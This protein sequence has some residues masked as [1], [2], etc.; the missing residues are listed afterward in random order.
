[1]TISGYTET[2]RLRKVSFNSRGWHTDLWYN[3]DIIDGALAALTEGTSIPFAVA[4]GTGDAI[5]LDFTPNITYTTS[6]QVQFVAS[7][8]NTGAVT[9]NCDGLGAKALKKADG[10]AY[11]AGD[12]SDGMY[13][14]AVYDSTNDYFTTIYPTLSGL[15]GLI[16]V[17]SGSGVS[18]AAGADDLV[19]DSSGSTP[20]MSILGPNGHTAWM[21]FGR[22]ADVDAGGIGYDHSAN[23]L[24]FR[25]NGNTR[26]RVTDD[27]FVKDYSPIVAAKKAY[28]ASAFPASG[29]VITS[30]AVLNADVETHFNK[31][32]GVFTCPEDDVY[33]V[34]VIFN[35]TGSAGVSHIFAIYKNGVASAYFGTHTVGVS[36]GTTITIPPLFDMVDCLKNDTLDVRIVTNGG[37]SNISG[38]VGLVIRRAR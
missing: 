16:T 28:S 30:W 11:E 1:M 33:E 24:Y 3:L 19:V 6:Q 10:S 27:G 15:S 31:T 17:G 32:T 34:N 21:Y 36:T 9:I 35:V 38:T 2:Y 20:G 25:N 8:V 7:A 22:V 26:V 18:A 5:T 14:R 29:T 37:A 4:A 13:I 12:I 23:E